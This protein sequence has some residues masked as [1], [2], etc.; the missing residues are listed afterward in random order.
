MPPVDT[1]AQGEAIFSFADDATAF[2]Y[3]LI[4]ANVEDVFAANIRR[5]PDGINGPVGVT[6]FQGD[7]ISIGRVLVE[8]VVTTPDEDNG[9]GWNDM[10]DI[11]TAFES[12]FACVNVETIAH[13]AGEIRGQ[14][15]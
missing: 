11:L 13:P 10:G 15:R 3:T 2:D 9:C 4:A 12:G 7:P 5:A 1:E 6:L 8:G 14:I